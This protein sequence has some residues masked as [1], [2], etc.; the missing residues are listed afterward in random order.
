MFCLMTIVNELINRKKEK[1]TNDVS[2]KTNNF[3]RSRIKR[4][5]EKE[6]K[7]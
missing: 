2:N 4:A 1:T 3:K 7:I 6:H 5:I